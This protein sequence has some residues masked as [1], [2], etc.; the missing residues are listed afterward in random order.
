L[1]NW[2]M[3]LLKNISITESK[4]IE[5]RFEAFNIFNHAQFKAQSATAFGSIDSSNFGIINAA[6]DP[7]ILQIAAKFRF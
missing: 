3:A 5:L 4:L 1:N 6:N 7:R 2:D